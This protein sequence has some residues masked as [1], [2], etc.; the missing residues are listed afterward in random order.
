[1][2]EITWSV[3][4]NLNV[5]LQ[6]FST[7]SI[8]RTGKVEHIVAY[9]AIFSNICTA[10]AQKRLF[11]NFQCKF[12]H[13]RSIPRPRFPIREQNFGDLAPFSVDYCI[14]YC[15]CPPY[16][17]FVWPTDLESMPHASTPTSIILT[18]FEVDMLTFIV[19][20]TRPSHYRAS[21][22]WERRKRRYYLSAH[23]LHGDVLLSNSAFLIF[24]VLVVWF[25]HSRPYKMF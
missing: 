6:S 15:E 13:Y 21:V 12:R 5:L 23:W 1:M 9:T 17:W 20:L 25:S 3:K 11:M 19:A 22:W 8:Y 2:R 16:F 18:K 10:H 7:T 24:A 4:G 14:L